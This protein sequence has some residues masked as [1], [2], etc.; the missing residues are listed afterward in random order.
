[1]K[2][3]I[4]IAVTLFTFASGATYSQ[5]GGQFLQNGVFSFSYQMAFPTGDLHAWMPENSYRGWDIE[6]TNLVTDNLA[7]GG[8]IGW[9]GFYKEYPKDTYEFP[10]GAVTTSLFKTFYTIPMH[11]VVTYYFVPDAFVQPFASILI[12]VNYNERD[13]Q[14][15]SYVI[16][17][18]SWNFSFA[19]EVGMIIPFGELSQWGFNVRARY[20]YNVYSRDYSMAQDFSGMAW[21]NVMTGLSFAF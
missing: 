9:Q 14:F 7:I 6:Y 2:K 4:I 19:P 1:M 3:I 16:E 17:D 5:T 10:A 12:G 20:L 11:G 13:L 18:Q 15:G 21:L 8:H